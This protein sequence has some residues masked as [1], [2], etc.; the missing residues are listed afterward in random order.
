MITEVLFLQVL[1]FH[2]T[3]GKHLRHTGLELLAVH[4][5]T[6]TVGY[7]LRIDTLIFQTV[8]KGQ[9]LF[10][11]V[12]HHVVEY[13]SKTV[14]SHVFFPSVILTRTASYQENYRY[15]DKKSLSHTWERNGKVLF[16]QNFGEFPH[17]FGG[18]FMNLLD[19]TSCIDGVGVDEIDG[20]A[21]LSV[22]E[23]TSG[24]IDHE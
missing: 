18:T 12:G 21:G 19:A 23:Q 6:S 11:L 13:R 20:D 3:K 22:V 1:I 10:R 5:G 17:A 4:L 8:D 7:A 14:D 9:S 15:Y 16:H 2:G 24:W